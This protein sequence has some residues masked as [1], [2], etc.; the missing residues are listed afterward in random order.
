MFRQKHTIRLGDSHGLRPVHR[1][2]ATI[3]QYLES[4]QICNV[5]RRARSFEVGTL[6]ETRTKYEVALEQGRKTFFAHARTYVS[7]Q[8]VSDRVLKPN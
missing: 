7:L 3:V 2:L 8:T 4:A 6:P 1:E 5:F